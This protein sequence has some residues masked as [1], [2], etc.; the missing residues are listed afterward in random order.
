MLLLLLKSPSTVP[1]G[2]VLKKQAYLLIAVIAFGMA[3]FGCS[4]SLKDYG[5]ESPTLDDS[6]KTY[7]LQVARAGLAGKELSGTA[8]AQVEQP[9]T[10]EVFLI[11]F[12]NGAP[13]VMARGNGGT[14]KASVAEAAAKLANKKAFKDRHAFLLE[15][16]RLVVHI[17]DQVEQLPSKKIKKLRRQIE[18]GLH[19]LILVMKEDRTFLLGEEFIYNCWGNVG[20]KRIL[21]SNIVRKMRKEILSRGEYTND[22]WK[23]VGLHKFTTVSFAEQKPGGG[24]IVDLYRGNVLVDKKITRADLLTAV[25]AGARNVA[26]N[27]K[28]NGKFGYIYY[29]CGDIFDSA[30]N[31]V[32]H[33]GTVYSLFQAYRATGDPVIATAAVKGLKKLQKMVIEPE[34]YPGV[35]LLKDGKRISLGANALFTL[36]LI[37]MPD[38]IVREHPEFDGLREKLGRGLLKFQMEDGSFYTYWRQFKSKKPPKKQ[39]V[40]YPGET[41]L[42]FVR[43][44]ESTQDPVW[45]QAAQKA[46]DYQLGDFERTGVPD[47]WAIQ[48]Y[49][50]MYRQ[51]KDESYANACYA[52][53]DELLT[54]QWGTGKPEPVPYPDYFGGP[55][56]STPPRSTPAAS[57]TEAMTE[58]YHAAAFGGDE[59]RMK[60]YAES[61]LATYWFDLN[62]QYR[63]ETVF[64]QT[65][66]KRALGGVRGSPIANDVRID[67]TQHTMTAFLHG[68]DIAEKAHGKGELD[69]ADCIVDV[70]AEGL[71]LEE[72]NQRVLALKMQKGTTIPTQ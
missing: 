37:E 60:K 8:P 55:D 35:A 43:L 10:K 40:Y 11:S 39:A 51:K 16:T 46:A 14:L 6:G 71:D 72:A 30:Y 36:A 63:P 58:A 22:D 13:Y 68:L 47:N 19:G 33:A 4:D 49:G 48:A 20:Q 41:F 44:Y 17:M 61:V 29:P 9:Y 50:R 25:A 42:A 62:Q 28:N 7:L 32:R 1:G 21:G 64:W 69:S 12:L 45:L 70:E 24:G 38:Q 15:K 67:Y 3:A 34:G 59:A 52:M 5:S 31:Y 54:H 65:F 18:G 57:R 66:P 27:Q 56:N 53:A 2:D 23:R 26:T